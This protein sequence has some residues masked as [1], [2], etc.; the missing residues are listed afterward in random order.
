MASPSTS[1]ECLSMFRWDKRGSVS[2]CPAYP[3]G[4]PINLDTSKLS[5]NSPQFIFKKFDSIW[6]LD[7]YSGLELL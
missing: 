7:L 1:T 3:G 2:E 6:F 5:W 4:D